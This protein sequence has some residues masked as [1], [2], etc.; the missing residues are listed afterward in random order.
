MFDSLSLEQRKVVEFDSGKVVVKACPGS[1]KTYSVSAR[2]AK[3][4]QTKDFKR[5]GIAALSFTN[6]ACDEIKEKLSEDFGINKLGYP[7]YLGTLDSFINHHVFLPFGSLVM[8]CKSQ[9]T[10]VG[11]PHSIWSLKRYNNDPYQFFDKTTFDVNDKLIKIAHSLAFPFVWKYY[12]KDES[13]NKNI[14]NIIEAKFELFKQGF[15]TQNDANYIALKVLE[16]YPM[17]A[18]NVA[19]KFNY[20]LIDE[21][22][23]TDEVTMEIINLLVDNGANNFMLIGDRDQSIFEWNNARP[24]LFD[25][26]HENWGGLE[27]TQNRRSSDLIR[28]FSASLSSFKQTIS[29]NPDVVNFPVKPM[30]RGYEKKKKERKPKTGWVV[31]LK[32]SQVSFEPILNEFLDLCLDNKISI[33]RKN[34]AILYRGS[35]RLELLKVEPPAIDYKSVPWLINQGFVKTILKGKY[36]YE[37]GDFQRGYRLLEKGILELYFRTSK[38]VGF[39]ANIE[40]IE[41]LIFRDGFMLYRKKI[42]RIVNL[43]PKTTGRTIFEWVRLCNSELKKNGINR[44]MNIEEEMGN[45]LISSYFGADRNLEHLFPFYCGTVH[46]AKGKTFEAVLLILDKRPTKNYENIMFKEINSLDPKDQEEM[47]IVY[48][49]LTRSRKVMTLAVPNSD[50]ENWKKKCLR[51]T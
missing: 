27:L 49:G 44:T 9:P 20:F 25:E 14:Q 39:V 16:S 3:L 26:K 42:F 13:V 45:V 8:G 41:R 23:D 30:I 18:A 12:N 24:E 50:V 11:E 22:Q 51:D 1:G 6:V 34:V 29:V 46:S 21:A 32:E 43:L 4:L 19:R 33:N 31:S 48:V 5:S 15:A 17:I 7:H 2:I 38:R 40:A 36:L 10:L 28:K 35:T 37:Q 47:R